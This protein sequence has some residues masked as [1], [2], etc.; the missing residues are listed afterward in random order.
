MR[1]FMCA[2]LLVASCKGHIQDRQVSDPD[3]VASN[4]GTMLTITYSK[5]IEVGTGGLGGRSIFQN[6]YCVLQMNENNPDTS[7][8]IT[9]G[10]GISKSQLADSLSYMGIPEHLISSSIATITMILTVRSVDQKI[11][12]A[13]ANKVGRVVRKISDKRLIVGIGIIGLFHA[14]KVAY[15]VIRGKQEGESKGA[16]AISALGT[17]VIT[18]PVVEIWRSH[19]RLREAMSDKR[20]LRLSDKKMEKVVQRIS[21]FGSDAPGTCDYLKKPSP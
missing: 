21:A 7:E 14:G 3:F 19:H 9:T 20:V 16:Q 18:G 5:T 10:G 8:L 4:D 17:G 12:P 15:R 11:K 1:L 13:E 6:I 2:L